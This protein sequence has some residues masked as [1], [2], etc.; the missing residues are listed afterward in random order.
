MKE[1]IN[2][3]NVLL[4]KVCLI[5]F[6]NASGRSNK[7]TRSNRSSLSQRSAGTSSVEQVEE[8]AKSLPAVSSA[9]VSPG[10]GMDTPEVEIIGPGKE[11]KKSP[12]TPKRMKTPHIK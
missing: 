11:C 3:Y 10:P 2:K 7:S 6:R 1:R 5:R 12:A 9:E 4:Y 8:A